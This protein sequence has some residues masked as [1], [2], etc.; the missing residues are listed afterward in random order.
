MDTVRK[1]RPTV[2]ATLASMTDAEL[3]GAAQALDELRQL[4]EAENA[5]RGGKAA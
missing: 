1:Y 3:V 5:R 2:T 4:V